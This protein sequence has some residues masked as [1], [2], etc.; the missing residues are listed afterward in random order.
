MGPGLDSLSYAAAHAPEASGSEDTP[1]YTPSELRGMSSWDELDEEVLKYRWAQALL[2]DD[3]GP[4]L[5]LTM[6]PPRGRG[7]T[8]EQAS[9]GAANMPLPRG[10]GMTLARKGLST[11]MVP[12]QERVGRPRGLRGI[13]LPRDSGVTLLAEMR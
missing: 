11:S 8:P 4:L 9:E 1:T 2:A 13:R 7:M 5:S 3:S 6:P 12:Q 10:K